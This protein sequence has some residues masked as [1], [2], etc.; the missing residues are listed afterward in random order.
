MPAPTSAAA[1]NNYQI[2]QNFANTTHKAGG[3]VNVQ[4][5]PALS[6]F[7]RYGWRDVDIFDDPN[8]PLPSGGEG[9]AFTYA[10]N[11]QLALGTTYTPTTSSL[12]EVR[13]G[14]SRTEG[15]KDPAALGTASALDAYGISGLPSDPRV[16]GGLPT[17][18]ITGFSTLGRQATNPQWQYPTVYNPK[19]NYTW[20]AGRHSLKTGYEMQHIQTEVQDVNPLYGRDEYAGSFSRPVGLTTANSQY[21]LADFMFGARSRYALSNILIANLRQNMHFTYLQD[22]WRVNDQLTLN[23]GLRYEYA[24]PWVERDNILSNFDPATRTMVFARDGSLQDRS[25]LKPD[26]NNFGPRLGAA[27]SLNPLTVLRGGY[28]ISYVHF[29]RAGGANVLPINGP[30]VINAVVNQ[31]LAT[32]DFRTTQQGYPTGLTDPSTFNPLASNITYMPE[33]YQSSRVQSWFASV[34]RELWTARW[35]ISRTLATARTV[36]CCSRISTRPCRTTAPGRC[37][38]RRADRFPS[39]ATSP[40][41][42]TAGN[43][44]TTRSRRCS[45][46]GWGRGRPSGTR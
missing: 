44:A 10:R 16:V 42:S 24:T 3:K 32:P 40:I 43:R 9:N 29:H 27:Y 37:R 11:K 5:S 45:I 7:G 6:A 28:G 41:R 30:Q 20:L 22:D 46:G 15:G 12:L 18:I 13:F 33:D 25:T 1:S 36:C 35:S 14:W 26:R 39:S 4:L 34:Q 31:T 21:N 19:V 17:Q 2:L 8:I 38:F 23:L